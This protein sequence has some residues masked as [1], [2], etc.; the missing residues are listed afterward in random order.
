MT[1]FYYN[2]QTIIRILLPITPPI[3]NRQTIIDEAR[4]SGGISSNNNNTKI[5]AC[6]DNNFHNNYEYIFRHVFG[7]MGG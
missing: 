2:L 4:W 6:F 1:I 7:H 5:I 3:D